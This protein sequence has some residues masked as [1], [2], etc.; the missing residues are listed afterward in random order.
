MA[1]KAPRLRKELLLSI[2]RIT[3][4]NS[5]INRL[6]LMTHTLL[7][8]R[9]QPSWLTST[10]RTAAPTLKEVKLCVFGEER[11]IDLLSIAVRY[12]SIR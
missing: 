9:T 10:N 5:Y 6:F 7:L 12:L 1:E 11:R 2:A 8:A 4:H 3:G